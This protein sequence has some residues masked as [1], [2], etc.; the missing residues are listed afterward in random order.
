MQAEPLSTAACPQTRQPRSSIHTGLL[1]VGPA[2][3][4]GARCG[5]ADERRPEPA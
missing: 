1:D 4:T 5:E 3:V 2:D